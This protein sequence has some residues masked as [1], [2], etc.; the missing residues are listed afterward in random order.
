M[1]RYRVFIGVLCALVSVLTF[2]M[3]LVTRYSNT[4]VSDMQFFADYWWVVLCMVV[5]FVMGSFL[6]KDV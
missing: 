1:N 4:Y 2:F 6:L 5:S 3:L